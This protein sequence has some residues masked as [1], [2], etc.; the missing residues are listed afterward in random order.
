MLTSFDVI[1]T[2]FHD[3]RFRDLDLKSYVHVIFIMTKLDMFNTANQIIIRYKFPFVCVFVDEEK[4]L[5]AT[6]IIS[7]ARK[8]GC[9]IFLL[10]EDII[11]V[12]LM[13]FMIQI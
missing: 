11:E 3:S 4:K 9:S 12:S 5:N 8:L 10:P 2:Y 13:D 1:R 7:V 6:Y